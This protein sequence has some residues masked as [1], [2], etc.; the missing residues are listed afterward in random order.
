[1]KIVNPLHIVFLVAVI[2]SCAYSQ[3]RQGQTISRPGKTDWRVFAPAGMG[4]RIEVPAKPHRND[5]LY[6]DRDP[7]GY[8]LIRVY[9]SS[10]SSFANRAYQIIVLF[11]SRTRIE[12]EGANKLA[13][14]EFTIGGDDAEP[15]SV[16][17]I[18][19]N[20]LK[21]TEF[22]YH[23]ADADRLGHRKG[24]I[25]D[26]RTRIFILIYAADSASGIESSEATR[27]FNRFKVF[28][29]RATPNTRLERTRR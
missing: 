4:F 17:S 10:E 28:G 8:K 9:E 27:F 13:G 23:L 2:T 29:I 26:A 16:S 15:E 19:L 6:G 1:M 5:D 14:L 11:P 22:I 7:E 21:G 18:R 20:G 12:R 25:I 3:S 24:W